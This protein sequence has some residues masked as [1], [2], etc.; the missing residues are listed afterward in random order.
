MLEIPPSTPTTMLM[1]CAL[2]VLL[3]E[4]GFGGGEG[5]G[6]IP[7]EGGTGGSGDGSGGVGSGPGGGTGEYGGGI[8]DGG[9]TG[10]GSNGQVPHWG[11][12]NDSPSNPAPESNSGGFKLILFTHHPDR[13]WVKLLAFWNME[14]MKR[15]SLVFQLPMS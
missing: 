5:E 3:L 4:G 10:G 2:F 12:R 6:D 7:G 1:R 9:G 15:A 14:V 13:S 8:G 11:C